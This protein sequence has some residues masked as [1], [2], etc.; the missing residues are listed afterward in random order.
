MASSISASRASSS[1]LFSLT[2]K[3][4]LCSG[5][6]RSSR[7]RTPWSVGDGGGGINRVRKVVWFQCVSVDTILLR[8]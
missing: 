5:R 2:L 1:L 3:V 6:E 4:S 8:Y 7:V